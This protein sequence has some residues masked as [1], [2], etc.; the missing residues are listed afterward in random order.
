MPRGFQRTLFLAALAVFLSPAPGRAQKVP[1]EAQAAAGNL[2]GKVVDARGAPLA[3]ST[4][5]DP[6]G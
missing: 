6:S 5:L 2:R 1:S 4:V 3:Q